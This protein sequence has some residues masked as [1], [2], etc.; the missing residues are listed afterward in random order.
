MHLRSAI[1]LFLVVALPKIPLLLLPVAEPIPAACIS[2]CCSSGHP[3]LPN[4]QRPRLGF[5]IER[6][7]EALIST[8]L[9]SVEPT[10]APTG[11]ERFWRPWNVTGFAQSSQFVGGRFPGNQM[12]NRGR[13]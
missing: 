2:G 1:F 3:R 8:I 7:F 5:S 10:I 12:G 6:G 13:L 9:P 4:C 11:F